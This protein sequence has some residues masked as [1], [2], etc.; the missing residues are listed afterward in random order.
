MRATGA[1]SVCPNCKKQQ[2][3][4][5]RMLY[6]S[7]CGSLYPELEQKNALQRLKQTR[8]VVKWLWGHAIAGTLFFWFILGPALQ[9]MV[10]RGVVS[11]EAAGR[12]SLVFFM[13]FLVLL[14]WNPV[15]RWRARKLYPEQTEQ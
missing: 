13:T 1:L 3:F 7:F 2:P 12:I 5:E 14:F 15:G 6:C 8:V 10:T 11:K 9:T 4:F